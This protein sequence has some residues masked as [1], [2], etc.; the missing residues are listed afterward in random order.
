MTAPLVPTPPPSPLV[1]RFIPS[2]KIMPFAA[3]IFF[4]LK[5]KSDESSKVDLIFVV[6]FCVPMF[7]IR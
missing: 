4:V 1:I 6:S 7:F 2:Q 3:K 5:E